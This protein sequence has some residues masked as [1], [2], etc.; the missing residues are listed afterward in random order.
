[1]ERAELIRQMERESSP[2]PAVMIGLLDDV[3]DPRDTRYYIL[4][5]LKFLRKS[6]G[7]FISDKKLQLWPTGL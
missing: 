3:I 5:K 6:K 7:D 2:F 1:M 4:N